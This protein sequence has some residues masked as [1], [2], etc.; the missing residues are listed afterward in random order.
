MVMVCETEM[1]M[2][3]ARPW[4]VSVCNMQFTISYGWYRYACNACISSS[5]VLV[6]TLNICPV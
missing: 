1:G 6:C 3:R 2:G 4:S 5:I